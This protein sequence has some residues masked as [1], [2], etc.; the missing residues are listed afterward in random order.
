MCIEQLALKVAFP[1]L[2]FRQLD[3]GQHYTLAREGTISHLVWYVIIICFCHHWKFLEYIMYELGCDD[4]FDFA[5][6][7]RLW[8]GI[9]QL[10]WTATFLVFCCCL[11]KEKVLRISTARYVAKVGRVNT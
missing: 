2:C 8:A 4:N 5:A 6:L 7:N 11:C 1:K 9:Y 10:T 3:G